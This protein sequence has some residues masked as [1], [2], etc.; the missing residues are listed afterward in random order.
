[1]LLSK[2]SNFDSLAFGIRTRSLNNYFSNL[3]SEGP[4]KVWGGEFFCPLDFSI[5]QSPEIGLKSLKLEPYGRNCRIMRNL[6]KI[7]IFSARFT[8]K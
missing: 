1:M 4:L 2:G 3:C 8:I 6:E 5:W 7:I